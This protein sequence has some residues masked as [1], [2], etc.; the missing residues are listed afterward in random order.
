MNRH[1]N[2]ADLEHKSDEC[3]ASSNIDTSVFGMGMLESQYLGDIVILNREQVG[4]PQSCHKD[5]QI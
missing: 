4:N 3:M 1:R 2:P 5:C